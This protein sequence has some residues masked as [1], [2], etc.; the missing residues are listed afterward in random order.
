MHNA[1]VPIIGICLCLE[2]I[3][4]IRSLRRHFSDPRMKHTLSFLNCNR[5]SQL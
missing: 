5:P 4:T 3:K 1:Y 2:K